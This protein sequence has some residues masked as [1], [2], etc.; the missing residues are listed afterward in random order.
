MYFLSRVGETK[1]PLKGRLG[2]PWHILTFCKREKALA[3]DG[4]RSSSKTIFSLSHSVLICLNNFGNKQ[5]LF[6]YTA[7][8]ECFFPNESTLC[9][10]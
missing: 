4:H 1:N 6:I 10:L 3:P 8:T 2:G 5:E 9:S 7:L